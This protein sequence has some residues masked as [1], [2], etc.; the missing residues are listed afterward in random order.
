MKTATLPDTVSRL[1]CALC[2]CQKS[3]SQ[4]A[5]RTKSCKNEF[6]LKHVLAGTTTGVSFLIAATHTVDLI[7][8]LHHQRVAEFLPAEEPIVVAESLMHQLGYLY[9]YKHALTTFATTLRSLALVYLA[10]QQ[11]QDVVRAACGNLQASVELVYEELSGYTMHNSAAL[12][13][14]AGIG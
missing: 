6:L 1:R 14:Q 3:I 7:R 13:W 9:E 11:A 5:Q 10:R 12:G 4:I 8:Q 2:T